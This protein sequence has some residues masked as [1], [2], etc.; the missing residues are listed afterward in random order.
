MGSNRFSHVFTFFWWLSE[1]KIELM[2]NP[3]NF[4]IYQEFP[5]TT[6]WHKAMI[7]YSLT[8]ILSN[9]WQFAPAF[10]WPLAQLYPSDINVF[11]HHLKLA[12]DGILKDLPPILRSCRGGND[13]RVRNSKVQDP[14]KSI[15]LVFYDHWGVIASSKSSSET[16][17][18]SLGDGAPL[19]PS[20]LGA[21]YFCLIFKY[22][23]N[24]RWIYTFS[25]AQDL[26][27]THT[28]P[29]GPG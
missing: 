8:I 2:V 26:W 15:V 25:F 3:A 12:L 28:E 16:G 20:L 27:P 11:L 13:L 23:Q 6:T 22:F 9:G 7:W 1:I 29:I 18:E 24:W 14:S 21:S 10:S 4:Y 17:S 19:P 5:S